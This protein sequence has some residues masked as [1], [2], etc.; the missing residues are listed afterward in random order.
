[1]VNEGLN[2]GVL[3]IT[4]TPIEGRVM[5]GASVGMIVGALELDDGGI[6]GIDVAP[7]LVNGATPELT[8]LATDDTI[9]TIGALVA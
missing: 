5:D 9:L 6:L 3:E 1:M 8:A 2:V 7:M 4:E